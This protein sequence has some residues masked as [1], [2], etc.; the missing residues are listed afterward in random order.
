MVRTDVSETILRRLATKGYCR[1]RIAKLMQV[2]RKV[3]SD[4]VKRW[5]ITLRNGRQPYP[6]AI[7][8]RLRELVGRQ[9]DAATAAIINAECP[10]SKLTRHSVSNW[11]RRNK[12]RSI[13]AAAVKKLPPRAEPTEPDWSVARCGPTPGVD[14]GVALRLPLIL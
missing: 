10:Q 12:I 8:T 3:I 11:R 6:L 5:N 13:T 14:D 4:R 9:T 1:Q 7:S 2:D